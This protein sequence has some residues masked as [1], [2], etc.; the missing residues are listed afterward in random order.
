MLKQF[1]FLAAHDDRIEEREISAEN[2]RSQPRMRRNGNPQRENKAAEIERITGI[3]IRAA[4]GQQLLLVEVSG[5]R[6]SN[7]QAER[8]QRSAGGDAARRRTREPQD[9]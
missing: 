7:Q 5:G 1:A 9:Q 3:G 8:A 4:G 2:Q 6:G